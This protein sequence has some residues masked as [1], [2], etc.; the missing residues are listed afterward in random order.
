MITFV[1]SCLHNNT[2]HDHDNTQIDYKSSGAA[3]LAPHL[4]ESTHDTKVHVNPVNI[5]KHWDTMP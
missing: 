5:V 1:L 3:T 2:V 4:S